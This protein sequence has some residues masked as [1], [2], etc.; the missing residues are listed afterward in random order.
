MSKK[1]LYFIIHKPYK[2]LSQFTDEDGNPGLGSLFELPKDVYPVGRLDLDSEGLLILTNDRKLNQR[3]LDPKFAHWRKYW[4]QVEG[5]PHIDAITQLQ[6]GIEVNLKGKKHHTLPAK[7]SALEPTGIIER[8][9]PVNFKKHPITSWWEISLCEGKNRQV[10]RM[11]AGVGHP[12]LRLI[13]VAIED[14][15]LFPLGSGEISQISSKVL[16]RKLFGN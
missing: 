14:L 7:V 16:H 8:V 12:V 10:R 9:P 2:V 13:R 3:L 4:V 5:E 11:F 15:S 6:T 1:P